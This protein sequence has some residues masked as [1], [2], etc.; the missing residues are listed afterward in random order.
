MAACAIQ[1]DYHH[2]SL[3]VA[4]NTSHEKKTGQPLRSE[5]APA[6][7]FI[8]RNMQVTKQTQHTIPV[9]AILMGYPPSRRPPRQARQ[10]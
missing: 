9:W 3:W 4:D 5:I 2:V 10:C 8:R 1:R 6:V 7:N